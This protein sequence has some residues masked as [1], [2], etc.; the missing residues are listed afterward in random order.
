MNNK[1]I[2]YCWFGNSPL[3]D[4]AKKCIDSWRRF[5]PDYEIIRWDESNYDVNKIQ[6]IRKAY[7]LK[8]W[9]FVSDYARFDILYKYGG[10]FLDTDVEM[11]RPFYELIK[12]GPFMGIEEGTIDD[13]ILLSRG[14]SA[15]PTY[16]N[17]GLCI[18][19]KPRMPIIKE[20]ISRYQKLTFINKR[21]KVELTPSPI[22]ITNCIIKKHNRIKKIGERALVDG[23]NIYPIEYFNPYG[24]GRYFGTLKITKNTYSIHHY[25]ASWKSEKETKWIKKVR[26]KKESMN[27]EEFEKYIKK[28]STRIKKSIYLNGFFGFALNQIKKIWKR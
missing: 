25:D 20:F 10:L 6:Y 27:D 12:N 4:R 14:N 23:M 17:P 1:Y 28:I 8:M 18:Y 5:M 11:I 15:K 26:R 24:E 16:I 7:E 21:G 3:S 2:H 19:S 9:A 13:L 22:V